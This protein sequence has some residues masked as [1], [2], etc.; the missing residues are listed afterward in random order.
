MTAGQRL[1]TLKARP[2]EPFVMHIVDGRGLEDRHP[3]LLILTAGG[4]IATLWKI[5]DLHEAIDVLMIASLRLLEPG[6]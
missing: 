3:E 2:F 5:P 1:R 6:E 4:R